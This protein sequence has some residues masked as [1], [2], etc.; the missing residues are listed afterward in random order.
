V[1]STQLPSGGQK[2]ELKAQKHQ[3]EKCSRI[4]NSG[5][6]GY[7]LLTSVAGKGVFWFPKGLGPMTRAVWQK[8]RELA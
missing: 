4:N 1:K 3:E 8:F 6:V 5:N 2:N 7:D